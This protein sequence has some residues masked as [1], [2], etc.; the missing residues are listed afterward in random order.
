MYFEEQ[1]A[2]Q[3]SIPGSKPGPRRMFLVVQA[4]QPQNIENQPYLVKGDFLLRLNAAAADDDKK[5]KSLLPSWNLLLE[6]LLL[7]WLV[8][9]FL[10]HVL[11]SSWSG[12]PVEQPCPSV[13]VVY[14][15]D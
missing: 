4:A 12:T 10:L 1:Y 3:Y 8:I 11:S 2:G 14:H 6:L 9:V 13:G 15:D 7:D 5:R